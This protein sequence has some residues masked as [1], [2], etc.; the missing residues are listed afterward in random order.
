MFFRGFPVKH[1]C[2][3]FVQA[4]TL[5]NTGKNMNIYKEIFE[6]VINSVEELTDI[7]K[8][9]IL[10]EAK[11]TEVVDARNLLFYELYR[12]GMYISIIAR[13][14]GKTYVCVRKSILNIEN[15]KQNSNI[16]K[17]YCERLRNMN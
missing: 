1:P 9:V 4:L 16:F 10:S 5:F 2:F 7:P 6:K 17:I 8:E 3:Y 12:R 15:R 13:F 14:T 11:N